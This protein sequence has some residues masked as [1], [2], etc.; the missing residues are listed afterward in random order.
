MSPVSALPRSYRH[1]KQPKSRNT[2]KKAGSKKKTGQPRPAKKSGGGKRGSRMG[3]DSA[4]TKLA[5]MIADPC[6][7]PLAR[8]TLKDGEGMVERVRN[9]QTLH[10]TNVNNGGYVVWF[11]AYHNQA[12]NAGYGANS[13]YFETANTGLGPVN[14]VAA[15]YGLGGLSASTI[16]D[17]AHGWL[18][19]GIV[20]DARTLGACMQIYQTGA[21]AATQGVLA[22]LQNVPLTALVAG[23]G[24]NATPASVAQLMAYATT[25]MRFPTEPVEVKWAPS[26]VTAVW[27]TSGINANTVVAGAT[28]L[29]EDNCV[30]LG[31]P[32]T[33][34]T[35]VTGGPAADSIRG[36]GFAW[37]G[38]L[39]NTTQ[40]VLV[41]FTKVFE[42]RPSPY[43]ALVEEPA[44]EIKHPTATVE[45]A[46][47]KIVKVAGAG[48]QFGIKHHDAVSNVVGALY[49]GQ[50]LVTRAALPMARLALRNH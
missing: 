19:R 37:S 1:A 32:A 24:V 12:G 25:K 50:S 35:T 47:D 46:L 13:F 31:N 43:S 6:M 34:A 27:H 10:I 49:G 11:P 18:G 9:T 38:L 4:V 16:S 3:S 30:T 41:D 40:D 36:I 39:T 23:G 48:W 5:R 14:T 44:K 45:S 22:V 8:G 17:P 26:D 42:W 2:A 21:V 15:P 33:V 28:S 20:Q 7:A 29:A